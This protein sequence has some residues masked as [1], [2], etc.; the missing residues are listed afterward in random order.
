MRY[1]NYRLT[2]AQSTLSPFIAGPN[3]VKVATPLKDLEVQN[4]KVDKA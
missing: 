1:G 3:S 2:F 4:I